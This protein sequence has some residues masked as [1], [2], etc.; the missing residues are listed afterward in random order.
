MTTLTD[1]DS[2]AVLD[3]HCSVRWRHDTVLG[4]KLVRRNADEIASVAA[5]KAFHN[6]PIRYEYRAESI[7]PLL[8]RSGSRLGPLLHNAVIRSKGY[9]QRWM[10]ETSYSSAKRSLNAD[11]RS[12]AGYRQF[13]KIVLMFAV[14][15]KEHLSESL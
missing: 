4:R 10:A 6:W 14:N 12:L 9:N 13:R 2:L 11:V 8:L 7:E 5:D 1:V 15:N 3:V